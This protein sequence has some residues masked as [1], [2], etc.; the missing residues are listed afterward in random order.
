MQPLIGT[1]VDNDGDIIF[2]HRDLKLDA[3]YMSCKRSIP[4]FKYT[5][6]FDQRSYD[7]LEFPSSNERG[8]WSNVTLSNPCI[9]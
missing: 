3:L 9:F 1:L 6:A 2:G 7:N 8:T 4:F 5:L